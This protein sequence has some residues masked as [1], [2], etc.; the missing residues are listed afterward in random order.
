MTN[1]KRLYRTREAM[2]GG[3]CGGIADYFGWDPTVVRL[4]YLV[5]TCSTAFAGLPI[6][7]LLW[8]VVPRQSYRN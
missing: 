3:V 6:Y 5:A 2:I 4:I 7:I 1:N 8:I